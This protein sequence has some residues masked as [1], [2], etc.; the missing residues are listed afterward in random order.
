M[1]ADERLPEYHVKQKTNKKNVLVGTVHLMFL[2]LQIP[3]PLFCIYRGPLSNYT[4]MKTLICC[5]YN[6]PECWCIESLYELSTLKLTGSQSYDTLLHTT[7]CDQQFMRVA[8]CVAYYKF[9][10]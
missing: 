10:H 5:K 9:T 2:Y 8:S 6:S 1:K 7:E 3:P 4:T